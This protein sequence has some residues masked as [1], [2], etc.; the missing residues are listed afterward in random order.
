MVQGCLVASLGYTGAAL[1][2]H[3]HS[4]PALYASI[5]LIAL[6]N[7]SV[8]TPPVQT[9]IS[10]F[11]DRRGLASGIVVGGF[12]SGALVFAPSMNWLMAKFSAVPTYLG[13]SLDLVSEGG[14]Q[15]AKVSIWN[16]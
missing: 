2:I 3:I 12:G 10:W 7:G 9:M 5:G 8:Y 13:Q 1:S 11:P 15:F 4:L 6:G 14:R 16:G